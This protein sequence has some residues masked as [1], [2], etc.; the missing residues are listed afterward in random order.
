MKIE[1]EESALE[2]MK[3]M[4]QKLQAERDMLLDLVI[5]FVDALGGGDTDLENDARAAIAAC[6]ESKV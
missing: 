5:D 4:V 3:I 1:I 2:T 6:T